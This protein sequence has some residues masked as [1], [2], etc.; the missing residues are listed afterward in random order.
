M[1]YGLAIA[2]TTYFGAYNS[3]KDGNYRL[4]LFLD[5]VESMRGADMAGRKVVWVIHDDASPIDF[6]LPQLDN[7]DVQLIRHSDNRGNT[8]NIPRCVT[9][10]SQLAPWTLALDSDGLIARDC[11]P[12]LW[13]LVAQYP[14]LKVFGTFNTKYHITK[15]D[16]G[17]HVIKQSLCEHGVLFKSELWKSESIRD[18][19]GLLS[20]I[21]YDQFENNYPCLKPSGVQHT[22]QYGLNGTLDD[23]DVEFNLDGV[24][25]TATTQS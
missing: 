22:G 11:F 10:A 2:T 12:R 18:G 3:C 16:K 4:R 7:V 25:C 21:R 20:N 9:H 1:Q 8:G 23:N 17:T 15:E 6:V 24:Q 13:R 5:E 19:F 14:T